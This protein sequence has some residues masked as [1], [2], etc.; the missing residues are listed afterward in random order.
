MLLNKPLLVKWCI[1][2]LF[3][4]TLLDSCAQSPKVA[5][6]L[7]SSLF[8]CT[9]PYLESERGM[10]VDCY[11]GKGAVRHQMLWDNHS[12]TW[13]ND[14]V[15]YKNSSVFKEEDWRY[16]TSTADGLIIQGD[17]YSCDQMM[18]GDRILRDVKMYHIPDKNSGAIGYDIINYGAWKLDFQRHI[19]TWASS[20]D[21][22]DSI[23]NAER[24]PGTFTDTGIT[25]QLML[26]NKIKKD[27]Q[28]DFGYKDGILIP[29]VDFQLV[30]GGRPDTFNAVQYS[31]HLAT[32]QM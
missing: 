5:S 3:G 11:W 23:E 24:L 28:V 21:S 31:P 1:V 2:C 10:M 12:P 20:I 16:R 15:I 7:E 17:V 30:T 9:I 27:A 29:L 4:G 18:L 25:I 22:L 14:D 8:K 13:V 26:G 6:S 32:L 19:L